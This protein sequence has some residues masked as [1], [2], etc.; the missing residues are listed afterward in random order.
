MSELPGV[1][2]LNYSGGKQSTCL[3]WMVLRG[4]IP[5][6]DPFLV[7]NADPGM[8]N[9]ETYKQNAAMAYE[10]G[11]AGVEFKTVAG[12][13]LATDLLN[14]SRVKR[15]DNPPYWTAP[16]SGGKVGQLMQKCT[17][18]YKIAPM[19]RFL[20]Q[21]IEQRLG[22]PANSKRLP[23]GLVTK[24]IGF[25]KGEEMRIKPSTQNYI[26]FAYPLID[27]GMGQVEVG[28]YY[29]SNGLALPPRSVCNACFANGPAM[30]REMRKERP[31]DFA[32][33]CAIDEAVRDMSSCGVEES[34]YV[35]RTRRPLSVIADDE[36]EGQQMDWLSCDSG[37]CFT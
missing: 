27:R 31:G 13:N 11:K 12:P 14:I 35:S 10:C 8:E 20:R 26:R 6:P 16:R 25:C 29:E 19:D 28:Q 22:Y 5:R 21:W 33:A 4:D 34:V 32:Q 7:L 17:K 3:L 23:P 9:S 1:T 18:H 37:Y 36:Y 30:Y 2:V 15:I 24:W